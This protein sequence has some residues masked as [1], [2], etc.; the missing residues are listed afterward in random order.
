MRTAGSNADTT[1]LTSPALLQN[2][3]ELIKHLRRLSIVD[4]QQAMKVSPALAEK[5]NTLLQQWTNEMCLLMPAADSFLGDVYSGLQYRGLSELAKQRA[6]RQL[7][8]VSGL[9]GVLR[10]RDGIYPYRLEMGY[11]IP[12][13]SKGSLYSYWGNM[14]ANQ[15]DSSTAVINLAPQEYSKAVLPHLSKETIVVT[16]KFLTYNHK[17]KKPTAVAVHAKIARG[18]FARWMLENDIEHI[19]DLN[20]FALLGYRHDA[21]LSEPSQ[22]V[23]VCQD[24]QGTG[25]SIK[26]SVASQ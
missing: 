26:K 2:A 16:P 15:L 3:Q 22:P 14:I 13:L 10:P 25:L 7:R 4:I 24:F 1:N 18:A 9:Y 19:N 5:T 6:D 21:R 11:K 17:T 23:F 8:I 20:Q 12:T